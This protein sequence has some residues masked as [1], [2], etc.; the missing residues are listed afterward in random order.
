MHD[1]YLIYKYL[2]IRNIYK[3]D[4]YKFINLI[5]VIHLLIY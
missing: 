5:F 1:K 2:Q 4:I 3:L